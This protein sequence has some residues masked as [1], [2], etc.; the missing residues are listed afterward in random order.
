M[1]IKQRKRDFRIKRLKW[2]NWFKEEIVLWAN[3]NKVKVRL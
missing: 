3:A 1:G 2:D